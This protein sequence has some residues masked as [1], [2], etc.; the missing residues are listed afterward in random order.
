[1]EV[2]LVLVLKT[3]KIIY[4]YNYIFHLALQTFINDDMNHHRG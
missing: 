1:M 4:I 2:L 3:F